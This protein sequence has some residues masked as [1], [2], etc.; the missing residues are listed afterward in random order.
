MC[1]LLKQS[2]FLYIQAGLELT[3][4]SSDCPQP[5]L[6]PPASTSQVL[7]LTIGKC[8]HTHPVYVKLSLQVG[9]PWV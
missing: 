4:Y 8:Y 7:G 1:V 5:C 3:M 9:G 2:T 6:N